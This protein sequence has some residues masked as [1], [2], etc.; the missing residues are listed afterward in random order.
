MRIPIAD[1]QTTV[2]VARSLMRS[3]ARAVLNG[4]GI[5]SVSLSLAFVDDAASEAINRRFLKHGGPTDV[6]TFRLGDHPLDGELVI[7]AEVAARVAAERGHDVQAELALYVVHGV[8][9]L[10][11]YDD[12]DKAAARRMRERQRHYLAALGLP[13]ISD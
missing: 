7:G 6:I 3:A 10:C 12:K 8:L 2:P 13:P 4:E 1:R 5:V 9:H 11:G